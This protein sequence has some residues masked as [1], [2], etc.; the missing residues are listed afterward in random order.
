[1]GGS[2]R[3]GK[4]ARSPDCHEAGEFRAPGR[5]GS[6]FD[7]PGDWRWFCLDH[8]RAFNAGYDWFDGMNA[9][10]IFAAQS[11]AAAWAS[12]SRTFR[13]DA[14]IGDTPRWADFADPLDAIGGRAANIRARAA[15]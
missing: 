13:P 7:G 9:E 8:V 2:T 3:M 12:E 11:P 14:G 1:M 5:R 15:G 6:G 10:E 4:N